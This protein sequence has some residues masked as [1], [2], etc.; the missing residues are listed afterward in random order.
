[1]NVFFICLDLE[2]VKFMCFFAKWNVAHYLSVYT[3]QQQYLK[4]GYRDL[5]HM[6]TD[7][8]KITICVYD[9][10]SFSMK[11]NLIINDTLITACTW[12]ERVI[13]C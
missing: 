7:W 12:D 4:S 9:R 6:L 13:I 11:I 10:Y 5:Y 3:M 8:N 2:D 1:M